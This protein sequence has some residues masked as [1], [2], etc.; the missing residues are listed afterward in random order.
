[1]FEKVN[2]HLLMYEAY[3]SYAPKPNL[4]KILH[5]KMILKPFLINI[6]FKGQKAMEIIPTDR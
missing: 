3:H 6:F 5:D 4:L 2:H 1:M